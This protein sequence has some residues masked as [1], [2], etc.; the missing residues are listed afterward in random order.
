MPSE[1]AMHGANADQST[2]LGQLGLDL[3]Q[4]DVPL[5]DDKPFDEVAVRLDPARV[6]VTTAR[7]GN[8]LA[9]LEREAPPA[10][11]ARGAHPK[12]CCSGSA[13]HAAVNRSDNPIPQI[14]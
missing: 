10:D 13:T 4:G 12:M 5:L 1:E 7:L 11:R 6:A 3:D 14:L 9:M 8:R 2:A